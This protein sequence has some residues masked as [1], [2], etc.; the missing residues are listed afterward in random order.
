MERK[1]AD[2]FARKLET[3]IGVL[4][5]DR[6]TGAADRRASPLRIVGFLIAL[7]GGQMLAILQFLDDDLA[8]TMDLWIGLTLAAIGAAMVLGSMLS[9]GKNEP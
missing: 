5:E 8:Y 3:P 2:E 4:E 9:K 6:K 7:I 1:R